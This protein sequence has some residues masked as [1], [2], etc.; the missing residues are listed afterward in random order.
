MSEIDEKALMAA[1]DVVERLDRE[2]FINLDDGILRENEMIDWIAGV[3]DNVYHPKS[4]SVE[5]LTTA[6]L[7]FGEGDN[8]ES[9]VERLR[10]Y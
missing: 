9:P 4:I 10:E 6:L 8:G 2:G 1:S 7:E 5:A 3:I